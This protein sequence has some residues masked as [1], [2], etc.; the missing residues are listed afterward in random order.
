MSSDHAPYHCKRRDSFAKQTLNLG[1]TTARLSPSEPYKTVLPSQM[2]PIRMLNPFPSLSPWIAM[3]CQIPYMQPRTMLAVV[4]SEQLLR[5][6]TSCERSSTISLIHWPLALLTQI[7]CGGFSS[8]EGSQDR[9]LCKTCLNGL[10]YHLAY[11]CQ[12]TADGRRSGS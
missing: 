3:L 10:P 4:Q 12:W 6:A 1:Q 9:L 2:W 5:S 8:R 11:Y 7:V